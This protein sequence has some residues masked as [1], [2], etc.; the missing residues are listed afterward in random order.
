MSPMTRSR[1]LDG[2]VPNPLAATYYAQRASAGLIIT[3]AT[4]VS[5]QGVGYIRTPGIHSAEQVAGWKQVTDAVHRGGRHDLRAALACRARVASGLPRRRACRSLRRR[6][7]SRARPSP[8]RA[9]AKIVT[10]RALETNEIPRH[11]RAVPP[12]APRTPRLPAST[13]SSCTAPTATC[14]TSSCATAPTSAPTPTAAA[15]QT[16]PGLPLEVADAVTGVWGRSASATSSRPI[17]PATRCR[18][19]I[20]SRRSPTSPQELEQA[21]GSSICM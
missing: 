5:P 7:R 13:A 9:S 6:C 2:N 18:I 16:A 11:R 12:G 15:S 19:P 10:P 20:R 17:F 14:S 8:Q 4:Q 1:A 21:R 3:E